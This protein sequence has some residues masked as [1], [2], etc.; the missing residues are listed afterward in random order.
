MRVQHRNAA[1]ERGDVYQAWKENL[2]LERWYAPFLDQINRDG[3]PFRLPAATRDDL[4]RRRPLRDPYPYDSPV[5]RD[6]LRI[7]LAPS[8]TLL[9][10]VVAV[11]VVVLFAVSTRRR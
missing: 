1:L 6:P 7:W 4:E 8:K 3:N 10:S 2:I 11:V 9:W 5:G